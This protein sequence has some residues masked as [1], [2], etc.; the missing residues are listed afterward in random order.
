[1]VT[2]R[3]SLEYEP[4]ELSFGTSGLRGLVA[5]MTDL[6][7]YI[8]VTGFIDY[9]QLDSNSSIYV[10]GDLRDSTPRIIQ[11]VTQAIQDAGHQ[12][13]YCGL[14]PTPAVA[15]HALANKSAC[16]MV[17]GS[18]I[19]A[20]RNGIKF[21]KPSGEVLKRDEA[22][23][24]SAV[25]AV[26]QRFYEDDAET[27]QFNSAGAL[28]DPIDLPGADEA[29]KQNYLARWQQ[30][31]DYLLA[32]K[33]IIVYQH[34]AV[35][36]DILVDVLQNLGAEV[37]PVGRSAEFIPIDTE[38]VTPENKQ[39]FKALSQQYPDCFAIVST[40]GDSDR[41]FVIDEAGTFYRGD[42]VGCV[43]A[44]QLGATFAATPISSNDAVDAF[45]VQ[46]Q[47]ESVHTKI[48]SPYVIEAMN[49]SQSP[50]RVGWEV[51]GG[52]MTATD[53]SYQ[54][55]DLT[56]LPTRDAF[57]PIL[58][59]LLAAAK[60]GQKVSEQ[61]TGLPKRYTGGGLIDITDQ[62]AD[63]FRQL[64]NNQSSAT[65]LITNK[66]NES[67]LGAVISIDFTDGIRIKFDSQNVIHIR[68]SGNAPQLRVYTNS[69]TQTQ[70]DTLAANAAR[71]GGLLEK[72]IAAV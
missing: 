69:N 60:R 30:F 21:Y 45:L 44:E 72:L 55:A 49:K 16:V 17:T 42:V 63:G 71:P 27:S 1:M 18:H 70:A 15:L 29:A 24:K 38:N 26:R 66:L 32:N 28:S 4:V 6:E 67:D 58:V 36:R 5:D 46:H 53:T 64:V 41:P 54:G 40:D 14:L 19:P 56:A 59:I 68:P 37:V 43:V 2:L 61:F 22:A 9:L 47:I 23:I 25:A 39:Y 8:N 48:G 65:Q 50:V 62:Q 35:G 31:K 13:V 52:F 12:P 20:D 33:Q 3:Q 11:V 51:N 7:C 10:A 57:L 34:S